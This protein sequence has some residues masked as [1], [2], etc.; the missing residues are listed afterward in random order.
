MV[1]MVVFSRRWLGF[2]FYAG[3]VA[4]HGRQTYDATARAALVSIGFVAIAV[5]N[6]RWGLMLADAAS[7]GL[8]D[9]RWLTD[10][11]QVIRTKERKAIARARIR[12]RE[13]HG[14]EVEFWRDASSRNGDKLREAQHEIRKLEEIIRSLGYVQRVEESSTKTTV[15]G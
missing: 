12:V 2:S 1:F 11:K 10:H 8:E 14:E 4:L 15:E 6:S 7:M 3:G 9:L 5:G 13:D